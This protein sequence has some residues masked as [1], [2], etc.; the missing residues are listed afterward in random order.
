[1]CWMEGRE[2]VSLLLLLWCNQKLPLLTNPSR[3]VHSTPAIRN[4]SFSLLHEGYTG[5]RQMCGLSHLRIGSI[6][7]A[8]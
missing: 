6:I 5:E 4:G 1:M 2:R 8:G 7:R 3:L